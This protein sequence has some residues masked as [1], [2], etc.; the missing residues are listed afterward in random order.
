MMIY[1]LWFM[2]GTALANW[3][4]T[5]YQSASMMTVFSA[6]MVQ[7]STMKRTKL[8]AHHQHCTACTE[9]LRE[10]RMSPTAHASH[11]SI[12]LSNAIMG[13]SSRIRIWTNDQRLSGVDWW[14][15]RHLPSLCALRK[16]RANAK[17]FVRGGISHHIGV[18]YIRWVCRAIDVVLTI[19]RPSS[20]LITFS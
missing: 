3:E 15:P 12:A 1:I 16:Y 9:D 17:Y 8:D 18:I 14:T 20:L 6:Y 5:W 13:H 11:H 2:H 4:G 7:E 10:D 19:V